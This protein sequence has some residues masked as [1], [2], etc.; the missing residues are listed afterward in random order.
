MNSLELLASM[1]D[2]GSVVD[3]VQPA[4]SVTSSA[5]VPTKATAPAGRTFIFLF[6]STLQSY[7]QQSLAMPLYLK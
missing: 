1:A 7:F 3:A 5:D 6:F 2:H 4:T